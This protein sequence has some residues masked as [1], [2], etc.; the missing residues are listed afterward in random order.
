MYTAF[1]NF[2]EIKKRLLSTANSEITALQA[3]ITIA[4]KDK[5]SL[6]KQ[7][8]LDS[9]RAKEDTQIINSVPCGEIGK[10][11]Q[12][13]SRAFEA[14]EKAPLL[15]KEFSEKSEEIEKNLAYLSSELDT[16]KSKRD[17]LK[18]ELDS[19]VLSYNSD[20]ASPIEAIQKEI[21]SIDSYIKSAKGILDDLNQYDWEKYNKEAQEADTQKQIL[22]EKI[23]NLNKRSDELKASLKQFE[24]KKLEIAKQYKE[25][26]DAIKKDIESLEA[27]EKKEE[28]EIY[29]KYNLQKLDLEKRFNEDS[30]RI[31]AEIGAL[32]EKIDSSIGDKISEIG[33]DIDFKK[34]SV[35]SHE[36]S[37]KER[38]E[39]L[40]EV[41]RQITKLKADLELKTSN[42][43]K[44]S[45]KKEDLK[46]KQQEV[47]EWAF[48]VKAFDKTGIPVLKLENSGIEITAIANELLSIFDNKFRIVFETTRLKAD[49]KSS[50]ETFDINVIEDD[51]VCEI[52]NKSG[53]QQVILETAIRLAISIVVRQQGRNIQTSFLDEADGSLDLESALHYMQMI[54]KTHDMAGVCNTFVITHRP[55]LLDFI[56]QQIR[57]KD[58]VVEVVN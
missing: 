7:H 55:E 27:Q 23:S 17:A 10:G 52:S 45:V 39:Q 24:A 26:K 30:N 43:N 50:K 34:E 25:R 38:K 22:T 6:V 36:E 57:L 13:L 21:A 32:L 12:F 18:D 1:P 37:L 4:Q 31:G 33:K 56:P 19:L 35:S 14:K 46:L 49:K 3:Q 29:E 20:F 28:N 40:P 15:L 47:K 11:C 48:L 42:E 16:N 9:T 2:I 5:G 54:R 41:D 44:I 58:G 8:E 51:G 53:G